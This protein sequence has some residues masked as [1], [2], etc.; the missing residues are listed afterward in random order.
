MRSLLLAAFL[1]MPGAGCSS[2]ELQEKRVRVLTFN[3]LTF[4]VGPEVDVRT[5][6]AI[7]LIN[8]ERPDLIALQEVAES[9]NTANR[10]RVIS[11]A[12]GYFFVWTATEIDKDA[13]YHGGPAVLS[14]WP[15]TSKRIV[16]LPHLDFDG[17]VVRRAISITSETPAGDVRFVGTHI[18][19]NSDPTR[20]ADQVVEGVRGLL[21]DSAPSPLFYAGDF[22]AEPTSRALRVLRGEESH[23]GQTLAFDDAWTTTNPMAAG[24]TY[25]SRNPARRID[26]VHSLPGT[27]YQAHATSCRLV[28]D[29]PERD[30][31]ASD[32]LGVLCDFSLEER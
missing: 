9:S 32:H 21:G 5:Q 11:E 17:E 14:R 3:L 23:Q 8:K 15:I 2:H 16:D 27:K 10:A 12:T 19:T 6:M 4:A 18:T 31:L 13:D 29:E 25:P 1:L 20:Q 7:D 22:N 26:Y 30:I 24:Y 28:L